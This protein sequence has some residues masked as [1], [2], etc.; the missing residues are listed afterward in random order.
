MKLI[1]CK[2]QQEK[3]KICEKSDMDGL[4][5]W[6]STVTSGRLSTLMDDI[7]VAVV[8]KLHRI[9]RNMRLRKFI[10]NSEDK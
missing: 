10:R 7:F 6:C 2:F 8:Q 9:R 1:G 3:V 4:K 5:L